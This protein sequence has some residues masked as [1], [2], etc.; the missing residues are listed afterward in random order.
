MLFDHL[1]VSYF[2]FRILLPSTSMCVDVL[3]VVQVESSTA[4][5]LGT[6]SCVSCSTLEIPCKRPPSSVSVG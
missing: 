1:V 2:L 6:L 5:L 4:V 3:T